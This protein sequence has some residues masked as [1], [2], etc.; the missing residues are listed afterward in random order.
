MKIISVEA[1]PVT[2]P[3][4]QPVSDLWGTYPSSRHGIVLLRGES[5]EYGA[6]EVAFAWFG[7]AHAFCEEINKLWAPQLMGMDVRDTGIINEKLDQLCSF[8]KRHLLAKAG[9]EMAVWD[10]LGKTLNL[11]LYQLL[12]GKRR[13][14]I[15]LTGGVSMGSREEMVESALRRLDEGYTELKIKIGAEERKDLELVE[16]IREHVPDAVKLRVD[17]NMGWRDVKQAKRMITELEK[18]GV[19]LVE[20]PLDEHCLGETAW[21][22]NQV[23]AKIL[24][25]EGVWDVADAK[26]HLDAGAA[27][28]LHVY[29]SEAGGVSGARKIF[30]LAEIYRVNCTIGSMPEGVIGAAASA[31][32]A[33]AMGNLAA[34]ASD[35]RGFTGYLEDV[36]EETLRINAGQLYVPDGP[37]LGVTIDFAK[38]EKLKAY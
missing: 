26:R 37:G 32:V 25:D 13:E 16:A 11:P 3:F 31:H 19:D 27:D 33:A 30:E 38:L 6:G 28:M 7:G 15:P 23:Q 9:V 17:V 14:R 21:L 36:T 8:S 20:Q 24:I 10:L 2:L 4:I 35:I 34:E 5:G 1:I 22:R 12:G 29:I 18:F